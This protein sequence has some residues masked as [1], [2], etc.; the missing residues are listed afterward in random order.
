MDGIYVIRSAF[1][2][3][4]AAVKP[5]A[6]VKQNLSINERLCLEL[7]TENG[8]ISYKL[9]KNVYVVGFGK[10]AYGMALAVEELLK[11]HIREAIIRTINTVT[12]LSK[13]LILRIT[14]DHMYFTKHESLKDGSFKLWCDILAVS[15]LMVV[16]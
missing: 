8:P 12:K 3:A 9:D 16:N 10:A 2:A 7:K 5:N 14:E 11:P 6:L 4:I 1:E 13:N 15:S